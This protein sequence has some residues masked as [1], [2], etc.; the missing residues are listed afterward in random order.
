M[1]PGVR[2]SAWA[3][4]RLIFGAA[5]ALQLARVD[6]HGRFARPARHRRPSACSASVLMGVQVAL[7]LVVLVVAGLFLRS[8]L[9]TR[10]DDPG[11]AAKACCS[12]PTI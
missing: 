7:A 4:V 8:F 5:P 11:F 6:P 12:P 2:R 3:S 9:D 1:Q 10:G